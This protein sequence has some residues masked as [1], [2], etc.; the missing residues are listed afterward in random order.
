M[1]RVGLPFCLLAVA[2]TLTD[3]QRAPPENKAEARASFDPSWVPTGAGTGNLLVCLPDDVGPDEIAKVTMPAR[4]VFQSWGPMTGNLRKSG[5]FDLHAVQGGGETDE[6]R[7]Y[8]VITTEPFR[9]SPDSPCARVHARAAM[10]QGFRWSH[11]VVPEKLHYSFQ[12]ETVSVS[13]DMTIMPAQDDAS[14]PE[15]GQA[16]YSG[17]LN[18]TPIADIG[19]P[20]TLKDSD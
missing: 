20:V 16:L 14:H 7:S 4:T 15:R 6:L 17:D 3:C 1:R 19:D 11:S 2:L 18:A 10:S 8:A 13:P 9:V 5:A 12:A